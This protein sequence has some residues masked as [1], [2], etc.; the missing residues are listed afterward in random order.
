M[1][2]LVIK[3]PP[4]EPL[5]RQWMERLLWEMTEIRTGRRLRKV[6]AMEMRLESLEATLMVATALSQSQTASRPKVRG[7]R[8]T[9][10]N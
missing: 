3:R 4:V 9:S 2:T 1:A 7:P 8:L 6:V 5:Q 10:M